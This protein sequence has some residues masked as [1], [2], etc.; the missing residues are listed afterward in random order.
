MATR[1]VV[2]IHMRKYRRP[3]DDATVI[4]NVT[5]MSNGREFED[6]KAYKRGDGEWQ[7]YVGLLKSKDGYIRVHSAR[8]TAEYDMLPV[9]GDKE[10]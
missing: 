9:Y 4:Y 6:L 5:T 8:Q 2:R 1:T 7:E 3:L 10:N